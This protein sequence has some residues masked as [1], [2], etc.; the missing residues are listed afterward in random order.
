VDGA[1]SLVKKVV[2]SSEVGKIVGADNAALAV[3]WKRRF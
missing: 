1:C 2:P 3:N